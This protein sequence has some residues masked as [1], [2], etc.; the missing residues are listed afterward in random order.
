MTPTELL[1]LARS[2]VTEAPRAVGADRTIAAAL[3]TRQAL[4]VA[5][6]DWW[7]LKLPAMADTKDRAQQITLRFYAEPATADDAIWA[8]TRLSAI[9][10]HHAYA[11]PPHERR[12]RQ[13]DRRGRALRSGSASEFQP[14]GS[15]SCLN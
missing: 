3:L 2:V 15:N 5:M 10:H 12:D 9:C 8:W 6:N 4:E 1:A 7:A 14:T 13:P 11:M